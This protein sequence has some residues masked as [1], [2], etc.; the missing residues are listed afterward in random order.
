M[1]IHSN[2]RASDREPP[3]TDSP[4]VEAYEDDGR[5][6]LFDAENP[7][8]WMEATLSVRLADKT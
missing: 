7:L 2:G 5:V 1:S 8:A 4:S 3:G 6:V